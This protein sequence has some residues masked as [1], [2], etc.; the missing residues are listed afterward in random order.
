MGISGN[1]EV[2]HFSARLVELIY[3]EVNII[4][5]KILGFVEL[6]VWGKVGS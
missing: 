2:K 1:M 3:Y 6:N 4:S 5:Y